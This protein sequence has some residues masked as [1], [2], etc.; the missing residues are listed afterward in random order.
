MQESYS[1]E[2]A[3]RFAETVLATARSLGIAQEPV[4]Q[5]LATHSPGAHT[6]AAGT[7]QDEGRVYA[8]QLTRMYHTLGGVLGWSMEDARK[9]LLSSNGAF[10]GK[11]PVELLEDAEGVAQ[12]VD[13]LERY[14]A[15][16]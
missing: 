12:L 16:G 10:Q 6:G 15:S 13:Y 7:D 8:H 4:A 1:E 5:A 2:G 3:L 14:G 9:W 11:R